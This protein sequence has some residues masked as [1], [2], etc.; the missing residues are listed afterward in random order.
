MSSGT[1]NENGSKP[2][3]WAL[4]GSVFGAGGN[5]GSVMSGSGS[6]ALDSV[7]LGSATLGPV[8]SS[9]GCVGSVVTTSDPSSPRVATKTMPATAA[10]VD[11]AIRIGIHGERRS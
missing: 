10:T 2:P 11:A 3:W 6:G 1:S 7:T 5:C 9:S 4:F 8:M